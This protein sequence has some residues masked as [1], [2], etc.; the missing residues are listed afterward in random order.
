MLLTHAPFSE[1]PSN[2]STMGKLE[3][4]GKLYLSLLYWFLFWCTPQAIDYKSTLFL[5]NATV[6]INR[7]ASKSV[8]SP[9]ALRI[10][11]LHRKSCKYTSALH[12]KSCKYKTFFFIILA[13]T[14]KVNFEFTIFYIQL[15]SE[16][17]VKQRMLF[18]LKQ[19]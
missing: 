15:C 5:N 12:R 17:N 14:L 7:I 18:F 11:A 9:L 10:S 19:I 3:Q 1:L 2:I 8:C 6:P 16:N 13:L 4:G